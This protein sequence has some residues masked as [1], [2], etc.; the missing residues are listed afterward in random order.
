M[1]DTS[2]IVTL[3]QYVDSM[4][5]FELSLFP[6]PDRGFVNRNKIDGTTRQYQVPAN[7]NRGEP[8][9]VLLRIDATGE[10]TFRYY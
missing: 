2:I 4:V 3:E 6:N 1:P 9:E 10:V 7:L 5:V 8:V